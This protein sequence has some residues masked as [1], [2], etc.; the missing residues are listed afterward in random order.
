MQS[1]EKVTEQDINWKKQ[2]AQ[3]LKELDVK[4][5]EWGQQ[6]QELLKTVLR[7]TFSFQG[8][9]DILDKKLLDLKEALK[10]SGDNFP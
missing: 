10:K 9:N 7:L 1:Q 2:Y 4:E 3:T 6:Q 8:A 5:K